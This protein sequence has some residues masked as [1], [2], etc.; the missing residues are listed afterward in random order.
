MQ[1]VGVEWAYRDRHQHR[2]QAVFVQ[3]DIDAM[4]HGLQG[5][6]DQLSI[7]SCARWLGRVWCRCT[8]LERLRTGSKPQNFDRGGG[9]FFAH[10]LSL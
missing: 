9:V 2:H 7:T 10:V 3:G 6:I 4:W 1:R 5:F 8:C